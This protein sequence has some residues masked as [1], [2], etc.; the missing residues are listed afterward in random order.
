MIRR[1][2]ERVAAE[3]L[4]FHFLRKVPEANY[5]A[6]KQR[7]ARVRDAI[8]RPTVLDLGCGTG[9]LATL[10][11]S[12]GYV[13][14][15]V[16]ANRVRF[17]RRRL[18]LYRFQCAD[19]RTWRND[20]APFDLVLV[21]GVL[22]HLGDDGARTLLE[23]ARA[24]VAPQGVVLLV[25]DIHGAS[26]GAR[27]VQS[28]EMGAHVRGPDEWTALVSSVVRIDRTETYESGVCPYVLLECRA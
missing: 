22:H 18:P 3:P 8:G 23:T 17:A 9:E 16:D 25:E 1:L 2:A 14:V 5:R 24:N 10:F 15:D 4:L 6:T 27:I 13:G 19:A 28:I 11:A 21:C 12:D 26:L 7:I 20:G